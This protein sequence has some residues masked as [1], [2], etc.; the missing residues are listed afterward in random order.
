MKNILIFFRFF[1]S[2]GGTERV[3]TVLA[4]SFITNGYDVHIVSIEKS[5][6][7]P[8]FYLDKQVKCSILPHKNV[9]CQENIRTL[10][11]YLIDN[12]IDYI[13]NNDSIKEAVKLCS[14]AK[15]NTNIK[16][17]TIHH[18]DI[19]YKKEYI[20]LMAQQGSG[21]KRFLKNLFFPLYLKY[22]N[23]NRRENHKFNLLKSDKYILLSNSF[24]KYLP[25]ND[26]IMAINNPLSYMREEFS[27]AKEN[28]VI[29]VGRLSEPHKR[30]L[31]SL[32]IWSIVADKHPDW[33]YYIVGDGEDRG[34]IENFI[35]DNNIPNV[36]LT[37]KTESLQYYK[38][39]K[40]LIMTSAFEGWPLVINE[41]MQNNCVPIVMYSFDS[42]PDIIA[43]QENG[44]ISPNNDIEVFADKL[45]RLMSDEM[46]WADMSTK[47]YISTARFIPENIIKQWIDMLNTL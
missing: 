9:A 25:Q 34:L 11:S 35:Q 47:A 14:E 44:F 23:H 3:F 17:V 10:H 24:K 6:D 8:M 4:N 33:K 18:G 19:V 30:V 16:L 12:E 36:V 41:A 26:K 27:G 37:G 43:D 5:L 29:L 22:Q 42:L 13:I 32:K 1:P 7:V 38:W 45:D 40:I 31:L 46:M 20:H 2:V 21:L 39:A 15:E 28:M